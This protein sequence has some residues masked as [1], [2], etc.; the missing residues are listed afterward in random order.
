VMCSLVAQI[1]EG[2][3]EN[4]KVNFGLLKMLKDLQTLPRNACWL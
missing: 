1:V 2:Q 4:L 3:I